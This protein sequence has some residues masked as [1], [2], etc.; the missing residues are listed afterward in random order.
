MTECRCHP[1]E[2]PHPEEYPCVPMTTEDRPMTDRSPDPL[3]ELLE[4]AL[5]AVFGEGVEVYTV[6]GSMGIERTV[7]LILSAIDPA[8][9]DA[10]RAGLLLGEVERLRP[11]WRFIH[12]QGSDA[13]DFP[14]RHHAV[15]EV[16]LGDE[17]TIG[18]GPTLLAALQALLAKLEA[19]P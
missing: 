10:M 13:G 12:Q 7:P 1:M 5:G 16:V 6:N 11:G 19:R 4:P 8:K 3:V 9:A 14:D 15:I 17:G 18:Q 2:S